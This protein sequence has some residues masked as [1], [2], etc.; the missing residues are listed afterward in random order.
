[1]NN[2]IYIERL[3]PDVI[4]KDLFFKLKIDYESI[5]YITTPTDAEIITQII[6]KQ[7]TNKNMDVSNCVITDATAGVGGNVI[8][9]AE[10]FKFV[11]AIEL[12]IIRFNYLV[13]NIDVYKLKNVKT[14]CDDMMKV[15]PQLEN[16]D[17]IFIDPPWGGKDYKKND[18]LKLVINDIHIEDCCIE[19]INAKNYKSKIKFIVL[20]LPSNYDVVYLREKMNNYCIIT[21]YDLN[22]MCIIVLEIN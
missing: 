22:K 11:N 5:M 18:R 6:I 20:K 7:L 13:N 12:N 16:N 2:K 9:F 21:Q 4:E 1:M 17:I 3:F 14:I 8:S 19:M 10:K 15:L